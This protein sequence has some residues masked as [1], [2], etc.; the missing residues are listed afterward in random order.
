M[1]RRNEFMAKA[2]NSKGYPVVVNRIA[3]IL[4]AETTGFEPVV[5]FKTT[6]I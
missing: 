5:V 1:K 2:E 3:W 4:M 6:T